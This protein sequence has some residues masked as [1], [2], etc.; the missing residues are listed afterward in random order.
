MTIKKM[1]DW[2]MM[3]FVIIGIMHY[4]QYSYDPN[5]NASKISVRIVKVK[6]SVRQQLVILS[7]PI[8]F[9]SEHLVNFETILFFLLH[10]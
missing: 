6:Q 8:K 4:M 7:F 1:S 9:Q 5:M 10:S 2:K 3:F